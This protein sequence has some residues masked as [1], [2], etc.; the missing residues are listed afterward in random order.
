MIEAAAAG[1]LTTLL[2]IGVDLT[3]SSV[4]RTLLAKA[5]GQT[6]SIALVAHQSEMTEL[7]DAALPLTTHVE[8]SGTFTNFADRVQHFPKIVDP[9]GESRPLSAMLAPVATAA[10]LEVVD[11]DPAEVFTRLAA[12][13]GPFQGL[14]HELLQVKTA[15][16]PAGSQW[17]NDLIVPQL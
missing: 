11:V 12:E 17:T 6:T 2:V 7:V 5:L 13:G 14:S 1:E 16:K 10:G 4:D 15:V 8:V 9:M 3:R